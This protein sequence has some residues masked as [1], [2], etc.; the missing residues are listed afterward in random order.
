LCW[1]VWFV[2]KFLFSF[3]C[4]H[5]DIYTWV[6][7]QVPFAV[8]YNKTMPFTRAEA[9]QTL[10]PFLDYVSSVSP[11]ESD[12]LCASIPILR[13]LTDMAVNAERA[14]AGPVKKRIHRQ[15][16]RLCRLQEE[17]GRLDLKKAKPSVSLGINVEDYI[18]SIID[19]NRYKEIN[20]T[21]FVKLF[22]EGVDDFPDAFYWINFKRRRDDIR[23]LIERSYKKTEGVYRTKK[24]GPLLLSVMR[25]LETSLETVPPFSL[26][27]IME[28]LGRIPAKYGGNENKKKIFWLLVSSLNGVAITHDDG[29]ATKLFITDSGDMAGTF[30]PADKPWTLI[31]IP[32]AKAS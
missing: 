18:F 27:E 2:V 12:P 3:C 7:W 5:S 32:L 21:Y 29:M 20:E 24:E 8:R 17:L 28:E 30:R 19:F 22:A 6:L 9:I 10:K 13:E 1:L 16:Y 23:D 26:S 15:Y 14:A 4:V 31:L 25:T 11:D